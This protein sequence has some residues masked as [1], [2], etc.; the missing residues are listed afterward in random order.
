LPANDEC[1]IG[2]FS[3]LSIRNDRLVN[4]R[5]A[6]EPISPPMQRFDVAGTSCVV[7]QRFAQLL[8]AGHEG[9][10]ADRGLRPYGSEQLF[11]G[12]NLSRP[13]GQVTKQRQRLGRDVYLTRAKREPAAWIETKAAELVAMFD[14]L[15]SIEGRYRS[16]LVQLPAARTASKDAA[17]AA[18]AG[19]VLAGINPQAQAE[20]KA[21]LARYYGANATSYGERRAA[22]ATRSTSARTVF[23]TVAI[24]QTLPPVQGGPKPPATALG[25]SAHLT[26]R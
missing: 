17:A 19:T 11:L 9:C 23:K 13:L 14:A 1:R 8:N 18:A 10:V 12:D 24:S 21:A 4:C 3:R 2:C 16:Y 6:D 25:A 7:A 15:N 26:G 22:R 20:M 5:L